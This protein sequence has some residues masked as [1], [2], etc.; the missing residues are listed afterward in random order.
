PRA[1]PS[2]CWRWC[3]I[4]ICIFSVA[5]LYRAQNAGSN[6]TPS[7]IKGIHFGAYAMVVADALQIGLGRGSPNNG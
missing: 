1:P 3:N 7:G 4:L 5:N 6:A 2:F